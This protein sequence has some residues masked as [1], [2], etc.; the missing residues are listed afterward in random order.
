MLG[1]KAAVG[2]SP[3]WQMDTLRCIPHGMYAVKHFSVFS[4]VAVSWN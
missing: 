2:R 3:V 1:R 4:F